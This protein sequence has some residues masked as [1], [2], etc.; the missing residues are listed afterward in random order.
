MS[1]TDSAAYHHNDFDL[2]AATYII[3]IFRK[4]WVR[5]CVVYVDHGDSGPIVPWF[6]VRYVWRRCFL[7]VCDA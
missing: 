6:V 5:Q 1:A 4:I 7:L 3:E 2:A